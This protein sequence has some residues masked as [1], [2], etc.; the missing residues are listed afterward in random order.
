MGGT[1]ALQLARNST[2][3]QQLIGGRRGG[4]VLAA[5]VLRVSQA[6]LPPKPMMPL[7]RFMSWLLPK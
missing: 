3:F 5:P 6:V 1:L 2:P 4:L 7:L